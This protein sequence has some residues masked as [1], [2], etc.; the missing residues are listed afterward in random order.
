MEELLAGVTRKGQVTIPAPVRKALDLKR[1]DVLVFTLPDA[2]TGQATVH[3]APRKGRSVVES[4]A[5]MLASDQPAGS[6]EEEHEAAEHEAL[7][8]E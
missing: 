8:A 4:T 1:G 2:P 5:G 7:A 3:R 6:L